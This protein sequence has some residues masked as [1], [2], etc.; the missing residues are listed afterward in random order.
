MHSTSGR[1]E[2]SFGRFWKAVFTGTDFGSWEWE[3]V[4]V[5]GV[6]GGVKAGLMK[7][8]GGGEDGRLLSLSRS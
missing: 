5:P 4:L 2:S 6:E 7:V 8:P 3:G 1:V